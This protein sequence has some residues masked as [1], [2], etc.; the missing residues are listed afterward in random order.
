MTGTDAG[1]SN[2]PPEARRGRVNFVG[3][4]RIGFYAWDFSTR[5]PGPVIGSL[6]HLDEDSGQMCLGQDN[7]ASTK[8]V[9]SGTPSSLNGRAAP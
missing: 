7:P 9:T 8:T 3:T 1:G 2:S 6:D 4:P 5:W